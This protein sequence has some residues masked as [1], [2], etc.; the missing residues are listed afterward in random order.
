VYR[1]AMASNGPPPP[2]ACDSC[3][4]ADVDLAPVHRVYLEADEDGALTVAATMPGVE[5]W[6]A[7]CRGTY[8]SEPA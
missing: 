4:A 6:C 3:G 5:R 2:A 1:A 7:A 8:P